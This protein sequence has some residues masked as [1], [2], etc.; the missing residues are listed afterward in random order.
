MNLLSHKTHFL[1]HLLTV[2]QKYR[3]N[4]IK[5]GISTD[6][7][8]NMWGVNIWNNSLRRVQFSPASE[9]D[10]PELNDEFVS[11][12]DLKKELSCR[13]VVKTFD[14]P[15]NKRYDK[16]RQHDFKSKRRV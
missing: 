5:A 12:T 10:G 11:I 16:K 3:T 6:N 14:K 15:Q 1:Q 7:S 4:A 2:A 9:F 13:G 8:D